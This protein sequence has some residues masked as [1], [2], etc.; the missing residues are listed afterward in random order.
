M[1]MFD[2]DGKTM[3]PGDLCYTN[4]GSIGTC[5]LLNYAQGVTRWGN[6][7]VIVYTTNGVVR[8]VNEGLLKLISKI[9]E[10]DCHDI[11]GG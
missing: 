6:R 3:L 8:G 4:E 1:L 5:V 11:F 2:K 9:E 10:Q 7:V